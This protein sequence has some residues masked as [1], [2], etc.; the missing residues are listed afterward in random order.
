MIFF[1]RT[2]G[3]YDVTKEKRPMDIKKVSVDVCFLFNTR[4]NSESFVREKDWGV[5]C[6]F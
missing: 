5:C 4:R 2:G 3:H 6:I 1:S